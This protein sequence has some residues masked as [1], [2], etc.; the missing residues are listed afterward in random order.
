[1]F[2]LGWSVFLVAQEFQVQDQEVSQ[3]QDFKKWSDP[4]Y[5]H[6]IGLILGKVQNKLTGGDRKIWATM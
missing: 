6:L 3:A 5:N 2:L 1:M 4:N